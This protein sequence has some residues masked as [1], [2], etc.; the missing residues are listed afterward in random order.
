MASATP[1]PHG[2]D[3]SITYDSHQEAATVVESISREV[4]EID[5]DR[6]ATRIEQNGS[7]VTIHIDA[8]D[9]VALRAGIN[10]WLSL[11]TVAEETIATAR[12]SQETGDTEGS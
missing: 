8:D 9:L 2:A 4:G 12:R 3:F 7:T 1:P 11:T 5:G 10:T 6:S